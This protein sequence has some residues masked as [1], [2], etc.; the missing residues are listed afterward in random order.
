MSLSWISVI[1]LKE[2]PEYKEIKFYS[3]AFAMQIKKNLKRNTVLLNFINIRI[4][5]KKN[6]EIFQKKI[7]AHLNMN[8]NQTC[9]RLLMSN[10]GSQRSMMHCL[11]SFSGKWLWKKIVCPAK[12][13]SSVAINT[14]THTHIYL[15]AYDLKSVRHTT[16]MY[17]FEDKLRQKKKKKKKGIEI[18]ARYKRW[19]IG[20]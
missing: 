7:T 18:K 11:Q 14:H 12:Y 5:R 10:I 19:R 6:S 20:E 3:C 13:Q 16:Q 17:F 9:L 1:K 8:E 4:K 2:I 15:Q